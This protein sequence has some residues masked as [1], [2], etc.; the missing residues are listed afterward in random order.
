MAVYSAV[1]IV[2]HFNPYPG[3]TQKDTVC[4]QTGDFQDI[5]NFKFSCF[6]LSNI[7]NSQFHNENHTTHPIK[8]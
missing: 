4:Q 3:G 5:W 1:F 7:E 6:L 8:M 2:V